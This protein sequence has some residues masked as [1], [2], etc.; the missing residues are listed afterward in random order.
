MPENYDVVAVSVTP[1]AAAAPSREEI[2]PIKA[3]GLAWGVEL[4]REGFIEVSCKPENLDESIKER[5]RDL[6]AKPMDLNIYRGST[7]VQSGP[8]IGFN[9]TGEETTLSLH[10]AGHLY[11]LR[12][13]YVT[14]DLV[15]SGTDQYLIGKGLVDHWQN[16][17][18][19]DFGIDV[20]AVTGSSLVNRDRTYLAAEENSIYH[21]LIELAETQNGFDLDFDPSTMV[22]DFVA[23]KGVDRTS[24]V[25]LDRRNITD[26]GIVVTVTAGNVATDAQGIAPS[27]DPL[28]TSTD[29][30]SATRITAGRR[31]VFGSFDGVT[32]QGTL[33]DKTSAL[34]AARLTPHL[35]PASRAIPLED[36]DVD[37]FDVGDTIGYAFDSGIG[38]VTGTYRV[39]K[40]SVSVGSDGTETMTVE[41][42]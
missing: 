24:T 7:L 14:T 16:L 19:G 23:S 25:V 13:M 26:P 15:Y 40:K 30:D 18:Y 9:L 38:I 2:A 22:L 35:R 37:S 34:L 42:E 4:N 11:N 41:F 6:M 32:V 36:M 17:A 21:R 5:L 12:Y 27:S 31:G 20:S 3:E 1:Q 10:A 39:E 29:G 33:D 28:L 8:V